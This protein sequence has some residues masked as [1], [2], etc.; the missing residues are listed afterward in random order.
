[1][2]GLEEASELLVGDLD[3]EVT[4]RLPDET[5][6]LDLLERA[7]HPEERLEV[8]S[9]VGSNLVRRRQVVSLQSGKP[10]AEGGVHQLL[11]VAEV[12]QGVAPVEENCS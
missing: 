5:R 2:L 4:E 9:E 7:G 6:V 1:M 10:R 8:L 3:R 11:V 12:H